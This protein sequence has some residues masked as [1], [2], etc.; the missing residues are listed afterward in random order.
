MKY[1]NQE[2]NITNY[3]NFI[4]FCPDCNNK[5]IYNRV[6]DLK[7][8]EPIAFKEVTCFKCGIS[9]GINCD[10]VSK[11]YMHLYLDY[12]ELKKEKKLNS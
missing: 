2:Q 9:Y 3:E 11:K 10:R 1:A 7:T 12:F 6:T 4:A 5:N 8:L